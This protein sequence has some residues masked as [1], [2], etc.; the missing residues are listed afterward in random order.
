MNLHLGSFR[1]LSRAQAAK[2]AE[3]VGAIEMVAR[4]EGLQTAILVVTLQKALPVLMYDLDYRSSNQVKIDE[5]R[6]I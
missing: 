1:P 2:E 4:V 6:T 5:I 3:A